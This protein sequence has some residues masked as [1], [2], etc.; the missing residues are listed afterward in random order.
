MDITAP[1]LLIAAFQKGDHLAFKKI[2]NVLN[3]ALLGYSIGKFLLT[4]EE[5]EDEV[6][7]C[8]VKVY[9]NRAKF[10][11]VSHIKRFVYVI[12]KNQLVD[13]YRAR[14]KEI[15]AKKEYAYLSSED[16]ALDVLG[17]ENQLQETSATLR[18]RIKSIGGKTG[19][20]LELYFFENMTTAEV[21]E[22]LNIVSQSAL[23]L[24][25][26]GIG[27]LRE[28]WNKTPYLS[29]TAN[30]PKSPAKT[31]A[32]LVFVA[33]ESP[34][35]AVPQ[36]K[37]EVFFDPEFAG[38]WMQEMHLSELMK[39]FREGEQEA[40]RY[41]FDLY[42][43][44]FWIYTFR[45]YIIEPREDVLADLWLILFEKR[46]HFNDLKHI[47]NYGYF[48]LRHYPANFKIQQTRRLKAMAI[49]DQE[50]TD[51][52][53]GRWEDQSQWEELFFRIK[54]ILKRMGRVGARVLELQFF[55]DMEIGE[56]AELL[57]VGIKAVY[58]SR[59]SALILL[60]QELESYRHLI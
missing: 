27:L 23:N 24:K 11:S 34:V 30:K 16:E 39:K 17:S 18:E 9:D 13:R 56:I 8:W 2:F 29:R 7:N 51:N 53:A 21:A 25:A 57:G 20:A 36:P 32:P 42:N 44:L 12:L 55:D 10:K 37:E 52:T 26:R 40:F 22:T 43:R 19:R 38:R 58:K 31:E 28:S 47:R 50:Y 3:T 6:A 46:A 15:I 35:V 4:Q 60:R 5:A 48:Y 54:A 1:D 14:G 45:L 49:L 33:E 41:V 59:S